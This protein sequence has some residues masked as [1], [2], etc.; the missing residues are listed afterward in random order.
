VKK[1][2][3]QEYTA[4]FKEQAIKRAQEAGVGPAS[5]EL[6][7]VEQTLR[8]WVKFAAAGKLPAPGT[9]P[10]TPE[11]MEISRLKA[12]NARLKMHVDI[13]KKATA[14]FSKDAL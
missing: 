13:L 11:Q 4:E 5:R 12:E 14:Y 10:V 3:K 2:P 7:L 1:I 8:N 9:K 6:G